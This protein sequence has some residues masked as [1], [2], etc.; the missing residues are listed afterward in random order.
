VAATIKIVCKANIKYIS[1]GNAQ[2]IT[3]QKNITTSMS[4]KKDYTTKRQDNIIT[5]KTFG[6]NF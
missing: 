6:V 3:I 4:H 5:L 2:T 1:D